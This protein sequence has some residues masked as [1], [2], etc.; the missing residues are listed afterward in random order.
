MYMRVAIGIHKAN[1][2]AAIETY[3]LMSQRFFTHATPTLFNGGTPRPQLSSCFLLMM[4][5]RPPPQPQPF[6][7]YRN[8]ASLPPPPACAGGQHL[9]D[10]RYA[11]ELR[12]HLQ[13][14]RRHRAVHPQHPRDEQLHPR[15][16]RRVERHRAHAPRLLG[17]G[18]LRRPGRREAQGRL[19]NLP[20]AVARGRLRVPRPQEEQRPRG[21]ARPRPVLRAVDPGPLHAG[22]LSRRAAPACRSHSVPPP[23][24]PQRVEAN[25]KWSLFC[26]N[27]APG[28][29]DVVGAE[30]KALYER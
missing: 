28:L 20:R 2:D 10:L 12:V 3:E 22:G 7:R 13:V 5:V 29:S 21:D 1:V 11:Q 26:P 30:F 6:Q 4:K 8:T 24:L 19:C 16:E 18:A 15:H 14:C 9:G 17:H 23:P 27:E 25:E